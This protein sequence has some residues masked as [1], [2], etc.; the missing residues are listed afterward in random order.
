MDGS[1]VC[2]LQKK[3]PLSPPPPPPPVSFFPFLPALPPHP[4]P[5]PS[6]LFQNKASVLPFL[7]QSSRHPLSVCC[8]PPPF[9]SFRPH[10]LPPHAQQT[11][12]KQDR[13]PLSQPPE[14]KTRGLPIHPPRPPTHTHTHNTQHTTHNTPSPT[15][16]DNKAVTRQ[17]FSAQTI[18]G[19]KK[20]QHR[21][22]P[23]F[24]VSCCVPLSKSKQKNN[25][26]ETI[27]RAEQTQQ[28]QQTPP[29]KPQKETQSR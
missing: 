9:T 22:P 19:R 23:F 25:K 20:T 16:L 24:C 17:A 10:A 4:H 27:G 3:I 14:E 29:D 12:Q 15:W 13:E 1:K 11:T 26:H 5:H 6:T 2:P 21:K 28:Q 18:R 7:D 8:P